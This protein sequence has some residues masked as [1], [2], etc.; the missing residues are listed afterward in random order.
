MPMYHGSNNAIDKIDL[1]RCNPRTDF[2][3]GF[4]LSDKYGTAKQWAIRKALVLGGMPTVLRYE[5]DILHLDM[6]GKRFPRTPDLKWLYF[7]CENRK[8]IPQNHVSKEPRHDYHWVSGPIAD[9]KIVDVV[10]EFINGLI[11]A[12]MA[13]NKAKALPQTYQL[14]LHTENALSFLNDIDVYYKQFK[15]G[16]WSSNWTKR[17]YN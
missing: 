17:K 7:I 1:D 4:Y 5:L 10:G 16:V 14:S 11:D 6:Y 13:I 12:E 15:N 3:K 2:G 9:D 8:S